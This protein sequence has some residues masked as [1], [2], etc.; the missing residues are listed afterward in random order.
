MAGFL[1][2][3][4]CPHDAMAEKNRRV[5]EKNEC[6]CSEKPDPTPARATLD[7]CPSLVLLGLRWTVNPL[8]HG[9]CLSPLF[10]PHRCYPT[11]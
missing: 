9:D 11:Y 2:A 8:Q 10:Q 1:S 5:H 4:A 6:V 3:H 7:S